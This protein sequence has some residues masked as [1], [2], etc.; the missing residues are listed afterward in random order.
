[1]CIH[2]ACGAKLR[3]GA[4]VGMS[5]SVIVVSQ[6]VV[7]GDETLLGGGCLI[8]DSDLHALPLRS[9][10]E[11]LGAWRPKCAAVRI[12][13]LVFLGAGATVLKGSTIGDRVVVGARSVVS[14]VIAPGTVVCG[15]SATPLPTRL[16]IG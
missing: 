8:T 12:D 10:S 9:V 6:E 2:V 5:N 16:K 4:D 14:G 1:M 11:G 3:I 15:P 7:I 13:R